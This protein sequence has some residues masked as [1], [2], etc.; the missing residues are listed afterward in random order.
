MSVITISLTL[1]PI[2][3][4]SISAR[5]VLQVNH[6]NGA[7]GLSALLSNLSNWRS[8]IRLIADEVAREV[9]GAAAKFTCAAPSLNSGKKSLPINTTIPM[10]ATTAA[11]TVTIV[12]VNPTGFMLKRIT[13]VRP[14]LSDRSTTASRESRTPRVRGSR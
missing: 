12:A 2:T 7:S 13:G 4:S 9:P 5:P 1:T 10:L 11:T 6:S 8:A 14:D 3:C